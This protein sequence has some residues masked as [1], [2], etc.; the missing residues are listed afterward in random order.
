MSPAGGIELERG[1]AVEGGSSSSS[2]GGGRELRAAA[3][4]SS[5]RRSW[6]NRQARSRSSWWRVGRNYR[7]PIRG[8][9]LHL[10]EKEREGG[11]W[12]CS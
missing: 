12:V 2:H 4:E 8:S 7:L 1:P 3:E 10:R 11:I 6:R 9:L 5:R